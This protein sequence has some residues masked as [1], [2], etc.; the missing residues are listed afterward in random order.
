MDKEITFV[1]KISYDERRINP[2]EI[3]CGINNDLES[4]GWKINSVEQKS[5]C[6][7]CDIVEN[8]CTNCGKEQ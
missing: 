4:V 8:K 1:V 3:Q 7:L 2:V 5:N 6:C